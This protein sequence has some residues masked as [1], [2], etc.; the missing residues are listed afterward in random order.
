MTVSGEHGGTRWGQLLAWG[1]H[2]QGQGPSS[3]SLP[4]HG[5]GLSDLPPR[6]LVLLRWG[7]DV[8]RAGCPLGGGLPAGHVP[9]R[10][11]P[12]CGSLAGSTALHL[13]TIA[14]QPQC[15]KVLLQVREGDGDGDEDAEEDEDGAEDEARDGGR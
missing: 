5:K 4:G 10:L 1:G 2:S 13:A 15:V 7:R 8:P 3:T 12:A 9:P 6:Y 14:C 11:W